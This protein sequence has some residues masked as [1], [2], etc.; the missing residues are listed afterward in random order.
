VEITTT[1]TFGY[2]RRKYNNLEQYRAQVFTVL[3]CVI[4]KNT[5][6]K[7]TDWL[8]LPAME[9]NLLIGFLQAK[10]IGCNLSETLLADLPQTHERN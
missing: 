7:C 8:N 3:T 9:F 4:E 5:S 10:K 6:G 2:R 1:E